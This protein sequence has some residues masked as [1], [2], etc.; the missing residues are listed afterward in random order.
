MHSDDV[1]LAAFEDLDSRTAYA[2]WQL[3]ESVFVVEQACP[4]P[5]LDGR[6]LEAGTRHL[7]L[8]DDGVPVAYLRILEDPTHTRIGRVLVA[9][10]HRRRGLARVLMERALK[11]AGERDVVLDAQ[12]YLAGWYARF[13]FA[14]CGPEFLEDGIAHIPMLRGPQSVRSRP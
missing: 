9:A 14:A 8:E 10:S 13:G 12:S 5:E 7:W 2:L 6:D 1:H 4:Y 11:Y 3:R